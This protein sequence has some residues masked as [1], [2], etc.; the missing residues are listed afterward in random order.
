M[1]KL[2]GFLLGGALLF[3]AV[4]CD[5]TRTSADALSENYRLINYV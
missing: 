4:S 2:T 1:K 5:T 3:G